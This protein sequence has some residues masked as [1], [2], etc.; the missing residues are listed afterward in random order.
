MGRLQVLSA[1][2]LLAAALIACDGAS[3]P[4]DAGDGAAAGDVRGD[5]GGGLD[6]PAP[7]DVPSPADIPDVP[8]VSDLLPGADVPADTIDPLTVAMAPFATECLPQEGGVGFGAIRVDLRWTTSRPAVCDVLVVIAGAGE[9]RLLSRDGLAATEHTYEYRLTM[10]DFW[11]GP[12]QVGDI[13]TWRA[14][15]RVAE[16]APE[17]RSTPVLLTLDAAARDCFWPFEDRCGDGSVLLCRA[18][19]MPCTGDRVPAVVR[20]CWRCVDPGTCSCDDGSDPPAGVYV[21]GCQPGLVRA[22]QGGGYVCASPLSCEP[23]ET[24]GC[25]RWVGALAEG[26]FRYARPAGSDLCW[27]G[28][29]MTDACESNDGCPPSSGAEVG[30]YC[31]QGSCVLCRHDGQCGADEVCRT[32]RCVPGAPLGC[33]SAPAC[34]APGCFLVTPSEVPCPVCVCGSVTPGSCAT[35]ED[36]AAMAAGPFGSCVYGRC[37]ECVSDADCPAGRCEPPGVCVEADAALHTL[38]GTWLAGTGHDVAYLRFEP[39]GALRRGVISPRSETWV[40]EFPGRSGLPCGGA[41]WPPYAA[42]VGYWEPEPL[43][44]T[45]AADLRLALNLPCDEEWGWTTSLVWPAGDRF[46][47]ALGIAGGRPGQDVIHAFKVPADRCAADLST[48]AAP[49]ETDVDPTACF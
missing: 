14:A 1:G 48:C 18:G 8:A 34:T 32:G 24:F 37:A 13:V 41:S 39:G 35:D 16:D 38:Y 33:P 28:E 44:G 22:V 36:C 23:D 25:P 21:P 29:R 19:L 43:A 2:L 27:T 26:P 3:S 7:A 9:G 5:G 47:A 10:Y 15:C 49:D 12:P 45:S 4:R 40:D 6:V 11:S 46:C 30:G 31:V 17:V 20:G 42:L